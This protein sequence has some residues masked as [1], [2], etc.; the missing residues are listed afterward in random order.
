[1]LR[2]VARIPAPHRRAQFH[3]AFF[4]LYPQKSQLLPSHLALLPSSATPLERHRQ[5]PAGP[6]LVALSSAA[7]FYS[8]IGVIFAVED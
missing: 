7:D 3:L 8:S 5:Q 1:M 2:H 6:S 4:H